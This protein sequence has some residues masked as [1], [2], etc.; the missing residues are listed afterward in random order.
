MTA[1]LRS[2]GPTKWVGLGSQG[3]ERKAEHW[4]GQRNVQGECWL[5]T[6]VRGVPGW[7]DL[8]DAIEEAVEL[9]L[10]G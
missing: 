1:Q 10:L 6:G 4:G 7:T 8:F 3:A 9:G 5:G 2:V